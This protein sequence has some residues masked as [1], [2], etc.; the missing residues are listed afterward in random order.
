MPAVFALDLVLIE[1]KDYLTPER[2]GLVVNQ[3]GTDKEE[4]VLLEI[5]DKPTGAITTRVA[6]LHSVSGNVLPLLNL[7]RLYYVIPPDTRFKVR[8]PSG[9]KLRIKG[10]IQKLAP[11]EDMPAALMTRYYAQPD[12]Y[13]T[14]VYGRYSHGTD[15]TLAA[16]AEVE[17][18]SLT[19]KTIETYRFASIAEAS[20]ENYTPTEGA[21]GIRFLLD[22]AYLDT[23][24]EV[25]KTGG[26]DILSMPRPPAT[27]TNMQPFS[28]AETPIEV[29]GDHTISV[30]ARNI[31]GAAISPATGTSLIFHVEGVA[32]FQRKGR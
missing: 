3:I 24:L 17:I 6:P 2:V 4:E 26:V 5:A 25:T 14:R 7:G 10:T 31:S 22:G 19:P 15:V 23:I 18:F 11:G 30:R 32:E 27:T 29:L 16:D 28:L 9:A 13:L 21:L 20:V 8:G 1:G 12:N